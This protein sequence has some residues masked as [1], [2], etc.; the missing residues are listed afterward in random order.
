MADNKGLK[1]ELVNQVKNRTGI[2]QD[3]AE[4]AVNVVIG[5]LKERLPS[6]ISSQIDSVL[7]GGSTAGNIAKDV[8]GLFGGKK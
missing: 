2:S 1:D 8:G 6:P 5:F 7:S 3:Q 4:K